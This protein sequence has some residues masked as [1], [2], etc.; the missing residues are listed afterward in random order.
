MHLS[1]YTV[2]AHPHRRTLSHSQILILPLPASGQHKE[3]TAKIPSQK[4]LPSAH[5]KQLGALRQVGHSYE[6][7]RAAMQPVGNGRRTRE[8]CSERWD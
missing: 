6:I 5:R 4:R 1:A 7:D 3:A 8:G 2:R